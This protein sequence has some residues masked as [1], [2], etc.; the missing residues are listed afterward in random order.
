MGFMPEAILNTSP[1]LYLYRAS[2]LNLLRALFCSCSTTGCV[3]SELD[4]GRIQGVDVP[5]LADMTF[6]RIRN[7]AQMPEEWL[8]LDL[9]K[10][11]ASVIALASAERQSVV[12]LDD[13]Q[14]RRIALNAGLEVWGTLRILLESKR[15]GAIESRATLVD[16]LIESG[17][18]VSDDV[19]T[20]VLR[21][22]GE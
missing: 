22:A 18:W 7:P 1:L 16:R 5:S 10:G 9:G 11:E 13:R 14:A 4:A 8:A 2:A 20:R 12:V 3:V 6:V 17:M 21:L 19:R 15:I